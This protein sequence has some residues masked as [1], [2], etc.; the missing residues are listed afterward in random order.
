[1]E[2]E[3]YPMI[4]YSTVSCRIEGEFFRNIKVKNIKLL[5]KNRSK[6]SG[7]MYDNLLSL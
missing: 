6:V 4:Y 7:V 3:E 2:E 5:T 1:M